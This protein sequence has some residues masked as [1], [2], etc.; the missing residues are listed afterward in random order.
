MILYKESLKNRQFQL[1]IAV[2]CAVGYNWLFPGGSSFITYGVECIILIHQLPIIPYV[3]VSIFLGLGSLE[4]KQAL[5]IIQRLAVIMLIIWL[6]ALA[7]VF[8]LAYGMFI[9]SPIQT[10]GFVYAQTPLVPLAHGAMSPAYIVA[11]I[12]VVLVAS[13]GLMH[14]KDREVILRPLHVISAMIEV[15]FESLLTILPITI[16]FFLVHVMSSLT[17]EIFQKAG[18]YVFLSSVFSLFFIAWIFPW[19]LKV[20]A[21][22]P[23]WRIRDEILPCLWLSFLAG[24]CAVALPL[25]LTALRHLLH[26]CIDDRS[27]PLLGVLLPIAFAVPMAGSIGNLLFIFFASLL[28]QTPLTWS[29]YSLIGFMGPLTMFSEPIVS[30]P[31]LLQLLSFPCHSISL[32]MLTGVM[33]DAIFDATEAFSIIFVCYMVVYSMER[34]VQVTVR[35]LM[36]F[37]LPTGLIVGLG[38]IILQA[39]SHF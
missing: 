36:I 8:V 29:H 38:C 17:F 33:T 4:S 19:A 12:Y 11:V 34:R 37:L 26:D 5:R 30:I 27:K 21:D 20:F 1:L 6:S 15:V 2:V 25:M 35:K 3:F 32:Y 14:H 10:E 31:A 13:F 16:F 39:S 24:D 7:L 18:L 22:M 28:Y 9:L 23:L